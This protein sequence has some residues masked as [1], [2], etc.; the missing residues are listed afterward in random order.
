MIGFGIVTGLLFLM[1]AAVLELNKNT[2]LGFALLIAATVG[3]A[4]LFSKAL[5]GS[6]WYMKFLGYAVTWP[7]SSAS[8]F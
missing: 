8:C 5:Q 3:F 4:V 2:L 7:S 6:K 1:M